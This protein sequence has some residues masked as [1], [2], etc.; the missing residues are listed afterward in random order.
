MDD[1]ARV[2]V[3]VVCICVAVCIVSWL[4]YRYNIVAYEKGYTQVQLTGTQ[5]TMWTKSQ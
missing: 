5:N 4:T 2:S 1:N 3:I